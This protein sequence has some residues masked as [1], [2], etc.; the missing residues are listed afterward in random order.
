VPHSVEDHLRNGK[1]PFTR[2]ARS[3]VIDGLGQA[4]QRAKKRDIVAADAKWLRCGVGL[5]GKRYSSV[6]PNRG[7]RFHIPEQQKG[8]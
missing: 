1:L 5:C 7:H 4:V 3:F 2:F 6:D 8:R